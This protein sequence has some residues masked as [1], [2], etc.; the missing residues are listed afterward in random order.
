VT[1]GQDVRGAQVDFEI[2]H[3][4]FDTAVDLRHRRHVEQGDVAAFRRGSSAVPAL[5]WKEK[6]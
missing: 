5:G 1:R 6:P 4:D 3:R 2:S